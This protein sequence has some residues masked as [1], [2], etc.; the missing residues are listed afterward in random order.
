MII[1]IE[2]L[3]PKRELSATKVAAKP[4]IVVGKANSGDMSPVKTRCYNSVAITQNVVGKNICH[5]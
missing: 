4:R 3:E 5:C 1:I 2:S